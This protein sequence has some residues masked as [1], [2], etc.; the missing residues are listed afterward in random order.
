M[1]DK[2]PFLNKETLGIG[3]AI[4]AAILVGAFFIWDRTPPSVEPNDQTISYGNTLSV[5]DMASV[6]DNK[7]KEISLAIKSI[8]PS[9]ASI[10]KDKNKATFHEVGQYKVTVAGSDRFHNEGEGTAIIDVVD[11]TPPFFADISKEVV[12]G[13]GKPIK[14]TENRDVENTFYAV[15]QDEMSDVSLLVSSVKLNS[16]GLSADSYQ[17]DNGTVSFKTVGSYTVVLSAEDAYGNSVSQDIAVKV[18]DQT[19]PRIKGL[20]KSFQ[21]SDSDSAPDYFNGVTAK[22]GVDGNLTGKIK[23]NAKKVKYG[24]PGRYKVK[25]SVTDSAGNTT[26]K[27]IPVIIK[28]K[29][30]PTI[31]LSQSEYSLTTGDDAPNYRD[32]INASDQIDGDLTTSVSID[33]SAVN[34]NSP[35]SYPVK[36]TVKDAAGNKR[37]EEITVSVSNPTP[38]RTYSD[39]DYDNEDDGGST[40]STGSM[41]VLVTRTGECYHNHKC[42][43]G[44]YYESTLAA[45]KARGLRPCQNCFR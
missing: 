3:G 26:A 25:Y 36:L 44:T 37:T 19:A 21:L 8:E 10:S 33:D 39:S 22:D 20:K 27:K 29:T 16:K 43:N 41:T 15:A 4:I 18:V 35:G 23:V 1:K 42:G 45:A 12:V 5:E 2:L 28:D 34:Y 7:T 31:S 14:T 13:Y 40:E 17:L 30:P 38:T 24:T 9:T 11:D 32:A 6:S